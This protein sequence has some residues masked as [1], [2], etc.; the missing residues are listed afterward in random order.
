MIS[1]RQRML[2]VIRAPKHI[3]EKLLSGTPW[4]VDVRGVKV[5]LTLGNRSIELDYDD[6][7][8]VGAMLFKG[9]KLAKLNAG[10]TSRRLIGFADLTDANMD[11]AVEQRL[12]DST[13]GFSRKTGEL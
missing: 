4:A 12:R 3:G 6:A 8:N 13:A 5:V 2:D 11:A 1:L 7:L 10:D 9:G